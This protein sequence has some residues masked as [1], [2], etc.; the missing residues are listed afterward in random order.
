MTMPRL[1]SL[2]IWRGKNYQIVGVDSNTRKIIL[3]DCR[4]NLLSQK[5]RE[6]GGFDE[7]ASV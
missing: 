7:P 5:L 4:G 1:G 2:W 6:D 3:S